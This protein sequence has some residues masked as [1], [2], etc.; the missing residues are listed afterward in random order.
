MQGAVVSTVLCAMW[1]WHLNGWGCSSCSSHTEPPGRVCYGKTPAMGLQRC[2]L[3]ADS[4]PS[5]SGRRRHFWDSPWSSRA[6]GT[7]ACVSVWLCDLLG[8]GT[9]PCFL[10]VGLGM[11]VP[12]CRSI[13]QQGSNKGLIC[14]CLD[15]RAVDL[16]VSSEESQGLIR[17]GGDVFD[18]GVPPE[19]FGHGDPRVLDSLYMFQGVSM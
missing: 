7:Q 2:G 19:I 8:R 17:L 14:C 4:I 9:C 10:D 11:W 5:L 1:C 18:V 16:A 3:V 6:L 13:F 15:P 12:H